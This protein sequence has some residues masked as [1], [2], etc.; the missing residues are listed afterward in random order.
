MSSNVYCLLP[1]AYCLL[2]VAYYLLSAG[3]IKLKM[4]NEKI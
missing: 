1:I 4:K 2:T 3:P